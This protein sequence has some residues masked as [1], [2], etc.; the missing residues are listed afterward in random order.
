MAMK[1]LRSRKKFGSSWAKVREVGTCRGERLLKVGVDC[2]DLDPGGVHNLSFPVVDV[3][4]AE[5]GL[6]SGYCWDW[7]SLFVFGC[8]T[9]IA[10]LFS[11]QSAAY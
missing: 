6:L 3:G 4:S 2:A 10:F 5:E 7:R 1:F 8:W 9:A 11:L